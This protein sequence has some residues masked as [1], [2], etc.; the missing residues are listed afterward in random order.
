MMI[1]LRKASASHPTEGRT[2]MAEVSAHW[3]LSRPGLRAEE[4]SSTLLP[5]NFSPGSKRKELGL[6]IN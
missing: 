6:H 1:F 5:L 3:E 2:L 4:V